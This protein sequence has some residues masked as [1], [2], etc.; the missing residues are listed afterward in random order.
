MMTMTLSRTMMLILDDMR[1]GQK[2]LVVVPQIRTATLRRP[3]GATA[4]AAHEKKKKKKKKTKTISSRKQQKAFAAFLNRFCDDDD[5][6]NDNDERE[7]YW[8]KHYL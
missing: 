6:V 1:H 4:S 7:D 3:L 8:K 2:R 5:D